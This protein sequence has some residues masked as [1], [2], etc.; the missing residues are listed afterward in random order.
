MTEILELG[1][2][3][4]EQSRGTRKLNIKQLGINIGFGKLNFKNFKKC[5]F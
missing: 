3:I 5:M 2:N 4:I 1:E